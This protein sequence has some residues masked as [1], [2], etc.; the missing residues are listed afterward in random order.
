MQ[1]LGRVGE[2]VTVLVDGAALGRDVAPQRSQ[3]LR[4]PGAAI[5]NQELRLVP[6]ALDEIVENRA[7]SLAGLAT[8]VLDRQ[9]HLLTVL[10]HAEH[11]QQHDRGGLPVEPSPHHGAVQDQANNRFLGERAG[12]PG[13]QSALTFRHTRLT[14]SLLI[15]PPNTAASARRGGC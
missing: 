1:P 10:T 13:I 12:I 7:P 15:A 3:R 11:D 9:Q 5:D 2:Q 14:V 4:Q 8:H 6:P